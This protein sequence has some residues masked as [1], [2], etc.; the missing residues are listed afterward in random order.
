MTLPRTMLRSQKQ[1]LRC[2]RSVS[3]LCKH[4]WL[5]R[6][7][8]FVRSN[9]P[10][11]FAESTGSAADEYERICRGPHGTVSI[12][13]GGGMERLLLRCQLPNCFARLEKFIANGTG[14]EAPVDPMY[15]LDHPW[16]VM[17]DAHDYPEPMEPVGCATSNARTLSY[18][19]LDSTYFLHVPISGSKRRPSRMFMSTSMSTL[20]QQQTM[21]W[22]MT[23]SFTSVLHSSYE[24]RFEISLL[25]VG[26]ANAGTQFHSHT[27][28]WNVLL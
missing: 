16:K 25:Y 5:P 19:F 2:E 7:I 20:L 6:T 24:T 21:P 1:I 27:T 15:V 17:L 18:Q 14:T 26:P 3:C 10:L 12:V 4:T 28:A 23:S 13:G 8:N 9:A 22:P 11:R